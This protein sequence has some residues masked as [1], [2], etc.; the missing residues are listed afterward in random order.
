MDFFNKCFYCKKYIVGYNEE[1]EQ[2]FKKTD[3]D[4]LE[5]ICDC[6]YCPYKIIDFHFND[7]AEVI[8][9]KKEDIIKNVVNNLN[10][11]LK[12]NK[13]YISVEDLTNSPSPFSSANNLNNM[14]SYLI[15]SLFDRN[16]KEINFNVNIINNYTFENKNPNSYKISIYNISYI[17]N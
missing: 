6:Y 7:N 10:E 13:F 16:M 4:V 1:D 15:N 9:G 14:I 3:L 2:K 17:K 11:I 8:L 12:G 5:D